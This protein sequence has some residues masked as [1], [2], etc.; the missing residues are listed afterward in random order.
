MDIICVVISLYLILCI[1]ANVYIYVN[2]N[3]NQIKYMF[4]TALISKILQFI[5]LCLGYT[6]VVYIIVPLDFIVGMIGFTYIERSMKPIY[7]NCF[8]ATH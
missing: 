3:Q 2:M 7:D 6:T 5:L 8:L 1:L 4:V